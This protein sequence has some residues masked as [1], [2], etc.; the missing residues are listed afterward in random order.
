MSDERRDGTSSAF[1]LPDWFVELRRTAP[2]KA[3]EIE[4]DLVLASMRGQVLYP[5]R[6]AVF[7][8]S[9]AIATAAD[10]HIEQ[11]VDMHQ[12]LT[13]PAST[14][15]HVEHYASARE[16][17]PTA[18]ETAR[19]GDQAAVIR[20]VLAIG[21]PWRVDPAVWERMLEGLS[22]S[23][24]QKSSLRS[25]A[26]WKTE[27]IA[28]IAVRH[29]LRQARQD[30]GLG[31]DEWLVALIGEAVAV[32]GE[33]GQPKLSRILSAIQAAVANGESDKLST[34]EGK[35]F[36][37]MRAAADDYLTKRSQS[38]VG[39]KRQ[40]MSRLLARA[41]FQDESQHIDVRVETVCDMLGGALYVHM[42][43]AYGLPQEGWEAK[44]ASKVHALSSKTDGKRD[45]RE[46]RGP[47]HYVRA[48]LRG[49]GLSEPEANDAT[50]GVDF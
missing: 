2:A 8:V 37:T 15:D 3:A 43:N 49:W 10:L 41:F 38:L 17:L 28:S 50:D 31:A 18:A 4:R 32:S 48:V 12:A 29:V 27:I 7:P 16:L 9:G 35:R 13:T 33:A 46:W 19:P 6:R 42:V 34:F 23:D 40:D 44:V 1:E 30:L 5:E 47:V 26:R 21:E 39:A 22:I 25:L 24:E 36:R 11:R 20:E 14:D 45:K